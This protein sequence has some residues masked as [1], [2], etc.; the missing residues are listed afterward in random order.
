MPPLPSGPFTFV[1][2]LQVTILEACSASLGEELKIGRG[3]R[4]GYNQEMEGVILA[5]SIDIYEPGPCKT[6]NSWKL[7]IELLHSI[8]CLDSLV[9]GQP[10]LTAGLD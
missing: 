10:N 8:Q 6:N 2:L 5:Y 1:C 4:Y 9:W 3:S 7:L